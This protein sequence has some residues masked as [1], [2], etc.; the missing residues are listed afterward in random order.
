MDLVQH[1]LVLGGEACFSEAAGIG[2][3]VFVGAEGL[4]IVVL[5]VLVG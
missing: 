2:E 5:H 3:E 1:F 4:P